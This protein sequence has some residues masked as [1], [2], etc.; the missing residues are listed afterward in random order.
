MVPFSFASIIIHPSQRKPKYIKATYVI[1]V[2][3]IRPQKPETHRIILAMVGDIIDYPGEV[4]TLTSDLN[5]MKLHVK[6]V[7]SNITS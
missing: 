1:L 3:N 2:C 5:T 6:S 7:I 4:I